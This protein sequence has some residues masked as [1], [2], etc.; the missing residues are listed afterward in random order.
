[1]ESIVSIA[2]SGDPFLERPE[3]GE[4]LRAQLRAP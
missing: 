1:M 4:K 3:I 2:N